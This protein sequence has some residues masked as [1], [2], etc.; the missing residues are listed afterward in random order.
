VPVVVVVELVSV[1]KSE[2]VEVAV[3]RE[4]SVL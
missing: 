4:S 1:K 3:A 2:Y